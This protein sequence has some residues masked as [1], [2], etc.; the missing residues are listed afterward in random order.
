MHV[1]VAADAE[2]HTHQER[3]AVQLLVVAQIKARHVLL[4]PSS[5]VRGRA[6]LAG[7]GLTCVV[8][9]KR[10]HDAFFTSFSSWPEYEL[11]TNPR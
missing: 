5:R 11:I 10:W 9:L 1:P 7:G 6:L 2:E 8:E 4:C 3:G